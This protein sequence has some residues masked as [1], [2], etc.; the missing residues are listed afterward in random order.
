MV[1][2]WINFAVLIVSAVFTLY[3]YVK[4]AGPAALEKKIGPSAY[5]KCTRYRIVASLF[6]TLAGVNYVVY[7]F[8][9]LP[10]SLARTFP[11]DWWVSGLIALLIAVPSGY[12]WGRGMKDAGE[13]TVLVRKEHHLYGGIYERMRHPQAV[14]ELPFWWVIA[15]LLHSPFLALFSLIWIPIFLAMCWAEERDLVL[16]YGEAYEEYRRRTGFL[17]PKLKRSLL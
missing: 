17:L 6:M 8:Y 5:D 3:F 4:S 2:A 16:R 12:L 15:F 9:P 7:Y 14:G 1:V 13:E 11:W 10:I